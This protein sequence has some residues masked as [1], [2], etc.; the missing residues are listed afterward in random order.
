M[1]PTT[2]IRSLS[3]RLIDALAPLNTPKYDVIDVFLETEVSLVGIHL[4]G[5]DAKEYPICFVEY[6]NKDGEAA[7]GTSF[8]QGLSPCV[9][10]TLLRKPCAGAT[11]YS[12]GCPICRTNLAAPRAVKTMRRTVWYLSVLESSPGH[13]HSYQ[14]SVSERY[15][16]QPHGESV[17]TTS[18]SGTT[19]SSRSQ[20]TF[21]PYK[22]ATQSLR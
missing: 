1:A 9:R 16:Y 6:C 7:E 13:R 22:N 12:S 4:L 20:R 19:T 17:T 3:N 11:E 10:K 5:E 18:N 14:P 8:S 15:V 21:M 2:S